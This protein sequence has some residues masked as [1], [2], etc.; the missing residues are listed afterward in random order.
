MPENQSARILTYKHLTMSKYIFSLGLIVYAVLSTSEPLYFIQGLCELSV[1]F[2]VTNLICGRNNVAANCFNYISLLFFNVETMILCFSGQYLKMIMLGNIAS[3]ESLSGQFLRYALGVILL[4]AFT[5]IPVRH[6]DLS[7][8]FSYRTISCVLLADL[9]F[10]MTAGPA[11]SPFFSLKTLYDEK[12]YQDSMISSIENQP[13]KTAAFYRN[14]IESYTDM[15]PLPGKTPN[16]VLIFAEGL[17]Q[18]IVDDERAVMPNIKAYESKSINFTNYYNH[19]AAT[20]RGIISQLYSG[21][22]AEDTGG[23][24]TLISIQ[25]ILS[26]AGYYTAFINTEPK[27]AD[28]TAFLRDLRFD[29]V[30]TSRKTEGANKSVSDKQAFELLM[31]TM[32]DQTSSD[33]PFFISMYTFGTHNTFDSPDQVFGDGSNALLNKFYNLDYQFG[34]FMDSFLASPLAENT[35]IVFTS[36]HCTYN[37]E[38]YRRAFPDHPRDTAFLDMIP[39][40]IYYDSVTPEVIDVN[41]RNSLDMAPS[42]LDLL[43]VSAPN[44]FLGSSL[45]NDVTYSDSIETVF[46][47]GN[48]MTSRGGVPELLDVQREKTAKALLTDY[49]IA[50]Q[51]EPLTP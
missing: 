43:G 29:K 33:K 17:S 13:D 7:A 49:F 9:V 4:I 36:D 42:L 34:A 51:Q 38:D 16:I 11:F 1:I 28:F 21:Y 2:L 25:S 3:F 47:A 31:D 23:S 5:F 26:D 12:I 8:V 32:E 24:N 18:N 37:T 44:Y 41:G 39:F 50:C 40:M 35:I 27:N 45:F 46:Y 19:T 15:T 48:F 22:H 6:F 20:Y 30:I 10:V 14:E